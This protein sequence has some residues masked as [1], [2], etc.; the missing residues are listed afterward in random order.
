MFGWTIDEQ[1]SFAVLDAY[2]RG[3][4][5]LHRHGRHLRPPR[6]RRGGRIR[7]HHRPLDRRARQPRAARD[8]HQGRHV[9]RAPRALA[10]TTIRRGIDGSL[11]RLGID[12]VDLYYAHKDDPDTPLEETLGAFGELISAGKIR[13]A[14]AS[15]YSAARLEQAM[16]DRRAGAGTAAYVALQPHYN[17]MERDEYEGEL[18]TRAPATGSPAFPTSV[19][20]GAS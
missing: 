20:R 10:R 2:F 4:R 7:A 18:A 11:S 8:R 13:Y 6:S 9:A 16:R 19:S 3:G 1:R 15:N 14:A 17:L 5:Q 12:T